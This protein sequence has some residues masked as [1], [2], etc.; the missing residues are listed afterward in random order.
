MTKKKITPD[1]EKLLETFMAVMVIKAIN[2][3]GKPDILAIEPMSNESDETYTVLFNDLK[4]V[5]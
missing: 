1:Y 3:D 5:A 2:L 4:N